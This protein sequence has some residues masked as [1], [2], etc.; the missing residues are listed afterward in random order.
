MLT[1]VDV[2]QEAYPLARSY[3]ELRGP[4]ESRGDFESRMRGTGVHGYD[5]SPAAALY[6]AYCLKARHGACGGMFEPARLAADQ[7][8]AGRDPP[9]ALFPKDLQ[10]PVAVVWGSRPNTDAINLSR[11]VSGAAPSCRGAHESETLFWATARRIVE[12]L[13]LLRGAGQG[14]AQECPYSV[15]IG[16]DKIAAAQGLDAEDLSTLLAGKLVLLGG[17]LRASNDWVES[18]VHGQ[19]PGVDYHAMALDNL[20]EFGADYRRNEPPFGVTE[21][22]KSFLEFTLVATIAWVVMHRNELLATKAKDHPEQRLTLRQYAPLYLWLLA[23]S[24]SAIMVATM[25]GLRLSH[26]API[27]WIGVSVVVGTFFVIDAGEHLVKDLAGSLRSRPGGR[28]VV[29][30][31]EH[32][33]EFFEYKH[34]RLSDGG[35]PPPSPPGPGGPEPALRPDRATAQET[36]HASS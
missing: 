2:D 15:A 24:A 12:Q 31:C 13:V 9:P 19:V 6:A 1:P 34:A 16:Y 36:S 29:G 21:L 35:H 4:A 18:P 5:L 22:F 30:L 28:K 10:A 23:L 27:N 32:V 25:V 33:V 11:A 3:D 20:V 17:H 26:W 7:A 8:L 14:S